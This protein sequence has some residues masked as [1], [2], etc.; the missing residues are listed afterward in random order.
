M[1]IWFYTKLR[2]VMKSIEEDVTNRQTQ[3]KMMK[4][5][6]NKDKR[7]KSTE[8]ANI[9]QSQTNSGMNSPMA[10]T[11]MATPPPGTTRMQT[12]ETQ[13]SMDQ[14]FPEYSSPSIDID[15]GSGS[16]NGASGISG[17]EHSGYDHDM[18]VNNT[19]NTNTKS[20]MKKV[21]RIESKQQRSELKQ[22]ANFLQLNI[23][24]CILSFVAMIS[25]WIST[26]LFVVIDPSIPTSIDV[27]VNS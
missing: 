5:N 20:K 22:N 23:K 26:F 13:G 15:S 11:P 24:L 25:N 10:T 12:L 7:D 3:M 14:A 16:C 21:K 6:K 2:A 27:V 18:S 8:N 19:A 4:M 1:F 9:I 17:D